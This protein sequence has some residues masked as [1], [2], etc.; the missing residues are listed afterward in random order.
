MERVGGLG[1]ALL[2]AY[3]A[4]FVLPHIGIKENI[5]DFI[6]VCALAQPAIGGILL[7]RVGGHGCRNSPRACVRLLGNAATLL[8]V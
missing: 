7:L 1:K 6:D 8:R 5:P 4:L 2:E 3:E